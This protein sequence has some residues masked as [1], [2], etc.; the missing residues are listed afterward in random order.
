[1]R[2]LVIG[3]A[4]R[5]G[6]LVVER[7][8][9]HGHEVT[10]LARR[11]LSDHS[12]DPRIRSLTGDVLEF[13][14]VSSAVQGHD[15]VI[16]TIGRGRDAFAPLHEPAIANIVHAMA[17]HGVQKLSVLSAAGTFARTDP[18]IS[19]KFRLLMATT[20]RAAYDDLEGMER[21]VMASAL[22]WT[23]VRAR[24]LSDDPATGD[25]RISL[26]G[27]I[28]PSKGRVSR[29]DVAGVLL[30]AVETT[31]YRRRAVVVAAP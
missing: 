4:G 16:V 7:A 13:D 25:Y 10:V 6:R 11:P 17:L 29:D 18:N 14:V 21:R 30:K 27:S 19:L 24:A 1:M 12:S 2:I 20:S 15:A 23:I 28:P 8:L 31:T 3:A 22:D 26:D 9:G 5:T